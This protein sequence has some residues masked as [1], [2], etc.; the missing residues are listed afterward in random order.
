MKDI[1]KDTSFELLLLYKDILSFL[2]YEN[3]KKD[4]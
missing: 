3:K 1:Y 4:R 2:K